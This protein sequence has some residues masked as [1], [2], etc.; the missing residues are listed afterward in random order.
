MT[1]PVANSF[2]GRLPH[3]LCVLVQDGSKISGRWRR[4][5]R[6]AKNM[7]SKLES[8]RTKTYCASVSGKESLRGYV[9]TFG[10]RRPHVC[11]MSTWF[12]KYGCRKPKKYTCHPPS[13]DGFDIWYNPF[14]LWFWGLLI[15]GFTTF[16]HLKKLHKVETNYLGIAS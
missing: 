16:N 13:G 1:C 12:Q 15:V 11:G 6:Q 5:L 10:S 4:R 3:V 7:R 2:S 14:W 9:T 8:A